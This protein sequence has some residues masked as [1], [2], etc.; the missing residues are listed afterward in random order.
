MNKTSFHLHLNLPALSQHMLWFLR[1]SDV[2]R[3]V[4]RQVTERQERHFSRLKN[5]LFS[6]DTGHKVAAPLTSSCP[7]LFNILLTIS[8]SNFDAFSFEFD[9]FRVRS[10]IQRNLLSGR[11]TYILFCLFFCAPQF[12]KAPLVS[13]NGRS[14]DTDI[15]S[16]SC[17]TVPW[18]RRFFSDVEDSTRDFLDDISSTDSMDNFSSLDFSTETTHN[19][20]P[21]FN[22]SPINRK[23]IE[24]V[25]CQT[26]K[27]EWSRK[28]WFHT[29]I[30]REESG[31]SVHANS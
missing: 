18:K 25:N 1:E 2:S 7:C 22:T 26:N 13:Y 6:P 30:T 14:D 31:A 10:E 16:T 8:S 19:L 4:G 5:R 28:P 20:I 15:V 27:K 12:L 23:G 24:T 9:A 21:L 11:H 17:G 29:T 3:H